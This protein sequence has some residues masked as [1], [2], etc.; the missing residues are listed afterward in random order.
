MGFGFTKNLAISSPAVSM[1]IPVIIINDRYSMSR[2]FF[3][4]TEFG[5]VFILGF[6]FSHKIMRG[7]IGT[8]RSL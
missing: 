7:I 3:F 1:V 4:I 6:V 5:I 2:L 8:A